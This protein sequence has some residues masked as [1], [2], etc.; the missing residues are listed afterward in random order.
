MP[1]AHPVV[2]PEVAVGLP[3]A[4][5]AARAGRDRRVGRLQ[6]DTPPVA[7]ALRS[8]P[9]VH[10]MLLSILIPESKELESSVII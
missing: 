5:A 3:D 7:R 2:D 1:P 8:R 9:P 6:V 4:A 10:R